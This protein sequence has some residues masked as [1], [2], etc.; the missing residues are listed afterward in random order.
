MSDDKEIERLRKLLRESLR[1]LTELRVSASAWR[2]LNAEQ[3]RAITDHG[4]ALEREFKGA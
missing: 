2:G 3:Q 1:L 4:N